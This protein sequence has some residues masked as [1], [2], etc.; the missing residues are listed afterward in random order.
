MNVRFY[1]F[2]KRTNSTKRPTGGVQYSVILKEPSSVISPR[3]ALVW[4]GTG[5]PTAYNYARIADFG[6][7]YWIQNWTYQDRQWI[8]ELSVDVLASWKTEIGAAEKYVLRSASLWDNNIFDTF[9]P[10]SADERKSVVSKPTNW[11]Q[12]FASGYYVSNISGYDNRNAALGVA[13]FQ[14]DPAQADNMLKLAYDDIY[15]I[16]NANTQVT[17]VETAIQWLGEM[18]IKATSDLWRYINSMMWFPFNFEAV[19]LNPPDIYLGVIQAGKGQPIV[20]GLR[21]F[22]YTLDLPSWTQSPPV[23][24]A[25]APFV[26]YTLDFM[27]FGT[28]Q[29]DSLAVVNAGSV[30]VTVTVDAFT[31]VGIMRVFA[32]TDATGLLLATRSA[33]VGVPVQIGGQAVDLGDALQI[34][35]V[36]GRAA[37]TAETMGGATLA[38]ASGIASAALALVP[39]AV[40]AGQTGNIAAISDTVNLRIR[41]LMPADEDPVEYGQPLCSVVEISDLSGFVL[42]RDGD[43]SAPATEGELNAISNYLTGGFFYE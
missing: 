9:Y 17:D 19:S 35:G 12:L 37:L 43:I 42:C 34:A 28:V 38:A 18:T 11:A 14:Q 10:A 36:S 15:A 41:R 4:T 23:W 27:P 8:C 32:G 20:L 5:S 30:Y 40:T 31:G 7:Y 16:A 22:N 24:K 21:T 25:C 39:D 2:S 29:L 3:L 26:S 33:Q 1:T 6:R 13:L